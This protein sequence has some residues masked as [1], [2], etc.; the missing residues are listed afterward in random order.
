MKTKGFVYLSLA[1][2]AIIAGVVIASSKQSNLTT[3]NE[4]SSTLASSGAVMMVSAPNITVDEHTQETTVVWR[5]T[6]DWNNQTEI[7]W[8]D[9]VPV[10]EN[11]N[12]FE[13]S[14]AVDREGLAALSYELKEEGNY[15]V[16]HCYLQMP[17]DVLQNFWLA[18]DETGIV[19]LETGINYR[20]IRA[21]P[22]CGWGKY[23]AVK[24][25]KG[26]ILDFQ[27][28]FPKLP[29]KT[30]EIAIY[31]V[32]NWH[33]RGWELTVNHESDKANFYDKAPE[34]RLPKLVKEETPNY[35]KSDGHSWAVYTDAHLIQPAKE[36]AMALWR[37]PEATYLACAH[38]QN[39][40]REYFYINPNTMLVDERGNSYR[41]KEALGLPSNEHVFW[42]EGYSGDYIAF[43]LVFE[44]LSE[45]ARSVSYIEP[46]GEPFNSWAANWKGET[47]YHLNIEELRKNQ[48]LFEYKARKIIKQNQ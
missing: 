48:P 47:I 18:S 14:S 15:T 24:S 35:T 28:Y 41:L 23:F 13:A 8:A 36:G 1:V 3:G 10:V 11:V 12:A 20:A 2:L 6:E 46:D 7:L 31:G 37:T 44:P 42:M 40:M 5:N 16:L 22:E 43:I 27:I 9:S 32:P 39:W 21:V 4:I 19:D 29:R 45:D 26:D 17:A 33:M 25:K 34:Y 38:E 30:T